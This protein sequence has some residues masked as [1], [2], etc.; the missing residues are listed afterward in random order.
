MDLGKIKYVNYHLLVFHWTFF[1]YNSSM[2]IC[3][4][5][6]SLVYPLDNKVNNIIFHAYMYPKQHTI[7]S[8]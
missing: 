5:L 6:L 8:P 1:I 4:S 2:S 7:Q 3:H